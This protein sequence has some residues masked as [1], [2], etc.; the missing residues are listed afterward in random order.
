MVMAR[1][2]RGVITTKSKFNVLETLPFTFYNECNIPYTTTSK[3]NMEV[4]NTRG[5]TR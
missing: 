4:D 2:I 5:Y 1:L 3:R